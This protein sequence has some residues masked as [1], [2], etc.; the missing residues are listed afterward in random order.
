[1]DVLLRIGYT[2]LPDPIRR[3]PYTLG[4]HFF[5]ELNFV[6]L[7]HLFVIGGKDEEFFVFS[8]I[9]CF[10]SL[11]NFLFFNICFSFSS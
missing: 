2:Y 6:V 3:E 8:L 10:I 1:M 9:K 11:I 5:S 4:R 7:D